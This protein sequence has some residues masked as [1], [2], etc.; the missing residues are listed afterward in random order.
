MG[1]LVLQNVLQFVIQN[2][3]IDLFSNFQQLIGFVLVQI[4]FFLNNYKSGFNSY[5]LVKKAILL[6]QFY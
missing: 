2:Q 1:F 6:V 3:P 4:Y 5:Y